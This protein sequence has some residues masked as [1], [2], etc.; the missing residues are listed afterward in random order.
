MLL[1]KYASLRPQLDARGGLD[2]LRNAGDDIVKG[3]FGTGPSKTGNA[4]MIAGGL[5]LGGVGGTIIGNE[6]MDYKNEKSY[7]DTT[8]AGVI[9]PRK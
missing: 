6:I 8:D 1:I 5:T 2:A 3:V 9:P 4:L 7:E